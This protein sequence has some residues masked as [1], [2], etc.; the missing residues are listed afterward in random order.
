MK[1]FENLDTNH[2]VV[3]NCKPSQEKVVISQLTAKFG[4][5]WTRGTELQQGEFLEF[6]DANIYSGLF[7]TIHLEETF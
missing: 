3:V 7:S 5:E 2:R 6:R 4:G 1:I